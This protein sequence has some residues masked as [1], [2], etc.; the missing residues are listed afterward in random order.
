[1]TLLKSLLQIPVPRQLQPDSIDLILTRLGV[2]SRLGIILAIIWFVVNRRFWRHLF[3]ALCVMAFA[4]LML[5]AEMMFFVRHP[6]LAFAIPLVV[7]FVATN[8]GR[9]GIGTVAAWAVL[10]ILAIAAYRCAGTDP[11]TGPWLRSHVE[12]AVGS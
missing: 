3:V 11:V 7:G 5:P 4:T 10:A 1:M 9:S 6:V 8:L 12:L 2:Y